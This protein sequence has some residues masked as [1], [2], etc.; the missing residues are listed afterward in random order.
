M[1]VFF[2]TFF[3]DLTVRYANESC[4]VLRM[5]R[6]CSGPFFFILLFSFLPHCGG[7]WAPVSNSEKWHFHEALIRTPSSCQSLPPTTN[8]FSLP[9]FTCTHTHIQI[10][11]KYSTIQSILPSNV[12]KLSEC[13]KSHIIGTPSLC[14]TFLLLDST[15]ERLMSVCM[16]GR[17]GP[18]VK[19]KY[20]RGVMITLLY[21]GCSSVCRDV[22]P[23]WGS[24]HAA[25]LAVSSA[26]GSQ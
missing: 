23:G 13:K 10:P 21:T 16:W 8:F 22:C 17:T 3:L 25:P 20:I 7:H 14:L 5:S 4:A 15:E 11:V 12:K 19:D 6:P 26:Q 2:F 24:Q 18:K 9:W 1:D